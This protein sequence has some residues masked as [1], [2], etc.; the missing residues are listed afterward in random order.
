MPWARK[1]TVAVLGE[2]IQSPL[3]GVDCVKWMDGEMRLGRDEY[4]TYPLNSSVQE[5]VFLRF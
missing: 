3:Y 1:L 2:G 4:E 5:W